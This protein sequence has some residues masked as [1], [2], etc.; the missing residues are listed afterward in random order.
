MNRFE[1]GY[2]AALADVTKL[3]EV[4][5]DVNSDICSDTILLD[6]ILAGKEPT[7][8]HQRQSRDMM[9]KG[10]IHCAQSHAAR[11]LIEAIGKMPRRA[12]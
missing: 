8:E 5:R 9:T 7:L 4:Y 12:A 1:R 10:T 3:A 6:P 11:H 2:R